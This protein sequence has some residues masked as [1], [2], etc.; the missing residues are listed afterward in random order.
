[1][2]DWLS[3]L[4]QPQRGPNHLGLVQRWCN[5]Q[6]VHRGQGLVQREPTQCRQTKPLAMRVHVG[7]EH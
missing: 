7:R 5:R 4:A 2:F 6:M 1:M 3:S